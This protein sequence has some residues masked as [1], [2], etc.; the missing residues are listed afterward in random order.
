MRVD[1]TDVFLA[2]DSE[3]EYQ[4]TRVS[5][6]SVRPTET[7]SLED[8]AIY[9]DSYF[10]EFKEVLARTWG[11]DT[12]A[13]AL[14]ILRKV[15][16]LGVAAMEAHGAPGREGYGVFVPQIVQDIPEDDGIPF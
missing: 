15:V 13:K 12:N 4:E 16:A 5:N 3:R 14:P 1:R 7:K 9:M 2:I 10:R 11:P 8:F 6:E